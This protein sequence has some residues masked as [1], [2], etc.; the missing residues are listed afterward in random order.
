[1]RVGCTAEAEAD[2][3]WMYD[4]LYTGWFLMRMFRDHGDLAAARRFAAFDWQDPAEHAGVLAILAQLETWKGDP[5]RARAAADRAADRLREAV[6][7]QRANPET[8]FADLDTH[9]PE[10]VVARWLLDGRDAAL[11]F[12]RDHAM[13]ETIWQDAADAH[14]AMMLR[15]LGKP[16]D[17]KAA[18]DRA[19]ARRFGP[20][21]EPMN[22]DTMH[23]ARE[24]VRQGRLEELEAYL[25]RSEAP[26]F[27]VFACLGAAQGML[28]PDHD[29]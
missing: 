25:Q 7:Q 23:L 29:R 22:W 4:G 26:A 6:Q 10:V 27:R 20:G 8:Y 13:P 14:A 3:S 11:R 16:D 19:L 24:M 15:R 2:E 21:D 17:A 9:L 12:G 18:L 28:R 5:A 1:M